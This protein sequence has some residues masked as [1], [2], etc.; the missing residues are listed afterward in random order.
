MSPRPPTTHPTGN[1]DLQRIQE[2]VQTAFRGLVLA[3][4]FLDGQ[5][6]DTDTATTSV[7]GEGLS[8]VAAT[9]RDVGHKLGRKPV[10]FFVVD[11]SGANPA[12]MTRDDANSDTRTTRLTST[13]TCKVKLWVF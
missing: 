3:C 4:K 2:Y 1:F 7:K 11:S 13:T 10:G 6:L 9:P 8:F 12:G 5:L